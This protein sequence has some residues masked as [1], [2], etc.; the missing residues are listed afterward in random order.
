[1]DPQEAKH[2]EDVVMPDPNDGQLSMGA[3]ATQSM[4]EAGPLKGY[5]KQ[6]ASQTSTAVYNHKLG[7]STHGEVAR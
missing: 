7:R 1:M 2:A 6:C 3:S 5:H 4:W